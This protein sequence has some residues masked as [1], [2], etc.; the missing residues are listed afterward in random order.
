MKKKAILLLIYLIIAKSIFSEDIFIQFGNNDNQ[1]SVMK[2]NNE[3]WF[4]RFVDTDTVGNIYIPDFYKNRIA[5]FNSKGRFIKSIKVS[6]SLTPDMNYFNTYD[7]NHFVSFKNSQLILISDR[8]KTLWSYDFGIG[9][10]PDTIIC[11]ED[12]IYV[13]MPSYAASEGLTI[14][15]NYDS[16]QPIGLLGEKKQNDG[17]TIPYF[18]TNGGKNLPILPI[19]E[20]TISNSNTYWIGEL[21]SKIP[22]WYSEYNNNSFIIYYDSDSEYISYPLNIS[23]NNSAGPVFLSTDNTIIKTFFSEEGYI[24]KQSEIQF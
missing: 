20:E 13:Y 21:N 6:N 24:L 22:I 5:V 18:M 10:F 3:F 7:G 17:K 15:F 12:Y 8:G 19:I 14:I 23:F 1:I 16:S 2:T 9:H 4:P 11:T